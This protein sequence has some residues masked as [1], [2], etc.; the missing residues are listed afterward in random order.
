[1]ATP[2]DRSS[3]RAEEHENYADDQRDHAKSPENRDPKRKPK[4][5]QQNT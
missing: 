2:A 5:K 4:Q 1:V 3:R